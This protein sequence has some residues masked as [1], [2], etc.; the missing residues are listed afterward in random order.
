MKFYP[1]VLVLG[2]LTMLVSITAASWKG[3]KQ[4][5]LA[6]LINKANP[7]ESLSETDARLYFLSAGRNTWPLTQEPVETVC[8][9]NACI[10]NELFSARVLHISSEDMQKY[11]FSKPFA[12]P[13]GRTHRFTSDAQ[14]I[15]FVSDT[16]G[17]IGY[18]NVKSLDAEAIKGVKVVLTLSK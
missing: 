7:A 3:V 9:Q 4:T 1:I 2:V 11:C 17:G 5:Q 8:R 14:I 12:A 6:I 16:P 10:E 18:V 15:Q 13:A